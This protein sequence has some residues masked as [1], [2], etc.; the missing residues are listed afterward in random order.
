MIRKLHTNLAFNTSSPFRTSIKFISAYGLLVSLFAL[1]TI[2]VSMTSAQAELVDLS[3][4]EPFIQFSTRDVSWL[5]PPRFDRAI[6][7]TSIDKY[8]I[9]CSY[10]EE[11]A[12]IKPCDRTDLTMVF[13]LHV[14][15]EGNIKDI[16]LIESSGLKEVDS[17]FA[18]QIYKARLKPFLRKGQAVKGRVALPITFTAAP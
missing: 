14:D 12:V 4:S 11:G 2:T 10:D 13:S 9:H 3:N 17:F 16:K 8:L 7:Y 18:K 15:K 6:R 5:R 1:F